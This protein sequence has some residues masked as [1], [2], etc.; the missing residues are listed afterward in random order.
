M[1][2]IGLLV[3]GALLTY[4]SSRRYTETRVIANSGSCRMNTTIVSLK[5]LPENSQSGSVVLLHGLTAN[6][7]IMMYLA[8]ALAIEGLRVYVPDSPGHGQTAGPFSP[9]KAEECALSFIRGLAARGMIVPDRTILAGHSM[10]A[11]I[12]LRAAAKI[13]VAGVIAISPAPMV[14][15]HGVSPE[16]L[17]YRNAPVVPPN[18]LIMTGE[19]EPEGLRGNAA[20]LAGTSRD[21]MS[22]FVNIGWNS[23]VSVLF[24]PTVARLSEEWAARVLKLPATATTDL[25]PFRGNLLGGLLGL[26]GVLV[27]AGPF[28][29]EMMGEGSVE[30]GSQGTGMKASATGANPGGASG[31]T[32]PHEATEGLGKKKKSNEEGTTAGTLSKHGDVDGRLEAGTREGVPRKNLGTAKAAVRRPHSMDFLAAVRLMAEYAVISM[33]VVVLLKYWMPLRV[34]HLFEGDYLASFFLLLG[35][36][37]MFLHFGEAQKRF[38]ARI[39]VLVSA[40]IAALILHLLITGWLQLT[41]SG[42]WMTVERWIRFP[43]AFLAALCFAYALEVTLGPVVEGMERQRIFI[44]LALIVAAWIPLTI[45]VMAW[46]SGEILLVL[47]APYFAIF[48]VMS[49]AGTQLVRKQSGSAM[50]AAV[51]NAILLAG[52]C[53]VIFPVS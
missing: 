47:M 4:A 53:L 52:F 5:G 2:G 26:L 17:L 25:R 14:T 32:V 38:R 20:D 7:V 31:V 23:H 10:G 30:R 11:A 35:L 46:H 15:G 34:L 16:V 12:A 9:D 48:F 29:R 42:A 45:G 19:F 49:R 51:F 21:G 36:A 41:I 43:L 18:T 22:K 3:L 8:R 1:T 50:A 13:R 33:G 24:S 39:A 40:G 28:L 6:K 27:I 37:V 44:G